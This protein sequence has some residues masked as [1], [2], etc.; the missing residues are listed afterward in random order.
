M[1]PKKLLTDIKNA[2]E[3]TL[4][5]SKRHCH[6]KS[7]SSVVTKQKETGRLVRYF[8]S[9]ENH[10][11]ESNFPGL[12]MLLGIHNHA[13]NIHIQCVAGKLLND[14]YERV[15]SK[16]ISVNMYTFKMEDTRTLKKKMFFGGIAHVE[17]RS[18][19]LLLPQDDIYMSAAELHTVRLPKTGKNVWKVNEGQS[20]AIDPVMYSDRT[21]A[22][23][24]KQMAGLY[25]P[26]SSK[27]EVVSYCEG[28]LNDLL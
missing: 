25:V 12:G 28:Y 23:I 16:A 10:G 6:V 2:D 3:Q 20:V 7:I 26:F 17:I 18:T 14:K 19:N 27:D 5:L 21:P 11:M 13:Y 4:L 8:M 15:R 24:E 1:T 22:E 9:E